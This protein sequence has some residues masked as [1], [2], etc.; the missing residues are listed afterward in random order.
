[1][2]LNKNVNKCF[3]ADVLKILVEYQKWKQSNFKFQQKL[4]EQDVLKHRQIGATKKIVKDMSS[5]Y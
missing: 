4:Y 1:M 5:K 3:D 2:N